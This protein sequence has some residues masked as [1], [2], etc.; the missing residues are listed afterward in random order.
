MFSMAAVVTSDGSGWKGLTPAPACVIVAVCLSKALKDAHSKGGSNL[1]VRVARFYW[2]LH[3]GKWN[4]HSKRMCQYAYTYCIV[5]VYC[6][7]TMCSIVRSSVK[8]S[9]PFG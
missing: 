1:Y 8:R 6:D 4:T 9:L 7:C 3:L 2:R 5:F